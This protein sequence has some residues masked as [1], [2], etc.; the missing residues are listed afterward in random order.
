MLVHF[1]ISGWNVL[2]DFNLLLSAEPM[3]EQA[4]VPAWKITAMIYPTIQKPEP[5]VEIKSVDVGAADRL[6][7][8]AF[9]FRRDALIGIDDQHPFVLPGNIFQRPILLA[10]QFPFQTNC[11]TRA[12]AA[13]AIA[14]VPSVLA[15]S[16]TTISCA[17]E[18]L[19]RHHAGSPLRS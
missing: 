2:A 19:P 9:Q 15:E 18:T 10:R 14:C 16:T 1:V 5:A 3:P 11:T 7:N 4:Q 6:A 12:P 13:S 17:N 8:F